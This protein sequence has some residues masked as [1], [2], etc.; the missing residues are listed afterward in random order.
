MDELPTLADQCS[1]AVLPMRMDS[2][3]SELVIAL[4][5][6]WLTHATRIRFFRRG[7]ILNGSA[8]HP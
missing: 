1:I 7:D 3:D 2:T 4:L 8:R 5:K 6:F